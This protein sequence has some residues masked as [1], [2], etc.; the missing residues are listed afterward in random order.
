MLQGIL[1]TRDFLERG[2]VKTAAWERLST[3]ELNGFKTKLLAVYSGFLRQVS[4]NESVTEHDLIFPVLAALGWSEF[5]TQQ[6]ESVRRRS[7]V[8]DVL[9]F[10]SAEDKARAVAEKGEAA[11]YRHGAAICENKAWGK[12]LDRRGG[13]DALGD[14]VPSTQV[15]RYLSLAEV[16]SEGKIVWGLLTN[17][18]YWRLYYQKARSRSEEFL[19]LDLPMILGI[20][21]FE[22]SLFVPRAP[23]PDHWLRVFYLFFAQ[24]AFVPVH[25][26]DKT[27]HVEALSEGRWWEEHVATNLSALVFKTIFP[28]LMNAIYAADPEKPRAAPPAEYLD[29]V[30]NGALILLYRLLF[31]LFAEDRHLLPVN[32]D[33]Y[34]DY[35]MR[36][37]V[38]EPVERRIDNRDTFSTAIGEYYGRIQR[39][40]KAIHD[41]DTSLG[42]PPYNG[43]LFDAKRTPILHRVELP[44]SVFAPVIDALSR[45]EVE[46][47]RRRINYRDLSVQQLGSIYERL[48]EFEPVWTD[49]KIT[50]RLN[51][52]ARKDTGSFYTPE[53][54]VR[55]IV[56]QTV[57]PLI[58][59]RIAI[60]KA[61]TA[62]LGS[63]S[64]SKMVR[65]NELQTRFDPAAQS[66]QL[67]IC[68]PAMGSGHFLVSLVDYLADRI[69]EAIADAEA[70]VDWAD[71]R[72]PY[73]SSVTTRIENLRRQILD[74]ARANRWAVD[75]GQLEDRLLVRRLI[76]KRV[77]HGVDMNPMAVELAKVALWLHTFTVGAPLSFL[78]HHLRCGNSLFGEWVRP[79]IDE[80]SERFK[81][82]INRYV[83]QAKQAAK[84]MESIEAT[85]DIDIGEVKT[86]AD[87]FRQVI[88]DT[89]PLQNILNFRHALRW[90]GA[91]S[92]GRGNLHASLAAIFD[93]SVGD[94]AKL[95]NQ[96]LP[97][98]DD[99]AEP[100]LMR[101]G[102]ARAT[103]VSSSEVRTNAARILRRARGLARD[104][105]FLHWEVAFPDVWD[106]W[107][108][109]RPKG[110]FDA[111][112]GNPPWDRIKMQEV[113]WF[114]ARKP[115]I[116]LQSRAADRN[117]MIRELRES[118]DPLAVA[119]DKARAMAEA[120]ADVARTCG[121][122]PLL[123]RGDIN[124]YSLFV[125][126][127]LRLL[128]P[129]GVI[130]LLTPSG[131][132]GDLGASDFFRSI[133]T[134]GRLRALY[135]FENRRPGLQPFFP[136]VDSRF[137]F[138][139]LIAGGTDRQFETAHCA[140]Y[141]SGVDQIADS[142][143]SFS[144]SADDFAAVN[145]NTGTAPI[146]RHARDATLTT[147]MYKR[148]PILVE[149]RGDVPK[150]LYPLRYVTMLHMTN[151]S[152]SFLS[153]AKLKTDG[154]YRT[155]PDRWRRGEDEFVPLY[156]GKMV[157]A[158]DHR[159]A[160]VVVNPDNVHRPAQPAPATAMQHHDPTWLPTPQYWVARSAVEWPEGLG[161]GLAFKDVTAP[162][163]VR[164]MI[165]AVIP[166]A[167]VGNTLPL[168]FPATSAD[169]V[170]SLSE[171]RHVA[172]LL[173]GNFNSFAFDYTARQ[174]VQGQHLNWFIVE[175][176]PVIP[177]SSYD[178]RI[179]KRRVVDLVRD[180]V[181]RLTYVSNDM[182]PFADDAGY[183]GP[184]FAWDDEERRHSRARLDAIYF[185]LYGVDQDDAAYILDTFPIVKRDDM[186]EL[187]RYRT[188]ELIL[189][190]MAA[191]A[192]GDTKSRIAA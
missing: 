17:G 125:E 84:G 20:S 165:A 58:D 154:A 76:L 124:I 136:D 185:M 186:E 94:F 28:D 135:D 108:T 21:G 95:A 189:G 53:E 148:V 38:R 149:R 73:R 142:S 82:T 15:L 183:S 78:D 30:R 144:L 11:R 187:G 27:F 59:E 182:K 13:D 25:K 37:N 74:R 110:G 171:Y 191:F 9:L 178:K 70:A 68:D 133:S 152:Q 156:E 159:A 158:F 101:E 105:S 130:G 184:P 180:E 146:F 24:Q 160:S 99:G 109:K 121:D 164:T 104:M 36:R 132:A 2:I 102:P 51:I 153:E 150:W 93:G 92:L 33:R 65:L 7:D 35:S 157:Q 61:K 141:L 56:E 63:D 80:I 32:D 18:R 86:S 45:T 75:P 48:L 77:I 69:L 8:P 66:L 168:L 134:T 100:E 111:V 177:P 91:S 170:G 179:G 114:A 188:K 26:N 145:P 87:T 155:A 1:F 44:D 131:I 137:K 98:F 181:L 79:A 60:F 12:P 64:R 81:L 143:R 106:D 192:A 40:F 22:P 5:L 34:D 3:E 118:N 96:G 4:P 97:Q 90:L 138:C 107:T 140:F 29:E 72:N 163:N 67:K 103:A 42:L 6:S 49:G 23:T 54:L 113:E 41:G 139:A 57:G 190:Y 119:Y 50:T 167:A 47:F 52:F 169:P 14:G 115:E 62:A 173:L 128:R 43:G 85:T 174:K 147:A 175:Q 129:S 46:L 161:W 126:R 71:S 117:R 88:D 172:P 162:T 176:L 55:L 120:E 16:Q 19:E 151:D 83:T 89:L 10:L 123:S 112:I 127:S 39:L 31:L 166:V 116:A 122:Y